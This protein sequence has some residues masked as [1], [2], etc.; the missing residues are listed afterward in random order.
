MFCLL[1]DKMHERVKRF[2][3]GQNT[4]YVE[5]SDREQTFL[6]GACCYLASARE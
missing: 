2:A 3:P 5:G 1:I 4:L 6:L